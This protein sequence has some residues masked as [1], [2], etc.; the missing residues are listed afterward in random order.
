MLIALHGVWILLKWTQKNEER[1]GKFKIFENLYHF[2]ETLSEKLITLQKFYNLIKITKEK[3]I[4]SAFSRGIWS[5]LTIA[6]T[7][8]ITTA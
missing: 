3:N 7:L 2:T 4:W 8:R 1:E 5:R 6:P